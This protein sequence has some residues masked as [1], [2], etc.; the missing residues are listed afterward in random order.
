MTLDDVRE[1]SRPAFCYL[2][3]GAVLRYG[4]DDGR[5]RCLAFPSQ[6]SAWRQAPFYQGSVPDTSWR[7]L[8]GCDCGRCGDGGC[9]T[10]ER[11]GAA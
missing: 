5:I 11:R 7:H 2:E 1:L 8:K 6:P 10:G 3:S 9:A 4:P